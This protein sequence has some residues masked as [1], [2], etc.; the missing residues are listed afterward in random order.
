MS[1][2]VRNRYLIGLVSV[3]IAV[4]A[5]LLLPFAGFT[6][7]TVYWL[8]YAVTGIGTWGEGLNFFE[9]PDTLMYVSIL[10]LIGVVALV[11]PLRLMWV[12]YRTQGPVGSEALRRAATI[13]GSVAV[14]ATL[15][16][17]L[18]MLVLLP[19]VEEQ[20]IWLVESGGFLSEWWPGYGAFVAVAGAGAA[21]WVL[22]SL[23]GD[24]APGAPPEET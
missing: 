15:T 10:M 2:A 7:K 17:L 9:Y 4:V 24:D 18:T 12:A 23:A 20:T 11:G 8:S 13:T 1:S 16:L 19:S 22:R 14:G 3:A 6:E 5:L 21:W